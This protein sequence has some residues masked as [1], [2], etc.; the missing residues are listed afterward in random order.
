[1][2]KPNF[3]IIILIIG[4]SKIAFGQNLQADYP[5]FVLNRNCIE[6]DA[7]QSIQEERKD[8]IYK[9]SFGDKT[10]QHGKIV[11]HCYNSKGAYQ[12][13]LAVIDPITSALHN[14]E[15]KFEVEIKDDFELS[16]DISEPDKSQVTLS[17]SITSAMIDFNAV[18]FWDYGDGNFGTEN[19][20]DHL[21]DHSGNYTIRLLAEITVAD[22]EPLKLSNSQTITIQ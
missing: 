5:D 8:L 4:L 18:Y 1:M 17:P 16:F 15:F 2:N 13:I 22:E 14:N 19:Q 3:L 12:V 11:E 20:H 7:S 9:W 10:E 6:L 21:Y